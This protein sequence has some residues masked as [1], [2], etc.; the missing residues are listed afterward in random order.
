[1]TLIGEN[2]LILDVKTNRPI[3]D[4]T[5][6]LRPNGMYVTVGGSI[7]RLLQALILGPLIS[8]ISKKTIAI[9]AL[10]VNK[11]LGY[12]NKLFEAGKVKPVI[13]G[14]YSLAEAPTAFRLFGE[15]AHKGKV[16]ISVEHS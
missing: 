15:G 16:V 4:Y 13:D 14:P 10:K 3:F 12:M 6:A 1:M 5:R 11:D 9:V 8:P 7:T 2:D